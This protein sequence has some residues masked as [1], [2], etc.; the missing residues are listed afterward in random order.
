M[1]CVKINTKE[2][3]GSRESHEGVIFI[4]IE[5]SYLTNIMKLLSQIPSA[6]NNSAEIMMEYSELLRIHTLSFV[7]FLNVLGTKTKDDRWYI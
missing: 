3:T 6:K 5:K 2:A 7:Y 4:R 1:V